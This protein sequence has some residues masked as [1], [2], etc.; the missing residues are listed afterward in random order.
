[1]TAYLVIFNRE[2][3]SGIYIFYI[4]LTLSTAAYSLSA[5]SSVFMGLAAFVIFGLAALFVTD[6]LKTYVNE[7]NYKEIRGGSEFLAEL[8]N[9][10][11]VRKLY[12][13]VTVSALTNGRMLSYTINGTISKQLMFIITLSDF[14]NDFC[15]TSYTG[16]LYTDVGWVAL[17]DK[18]KV[19]LPEENPEEIEKAI[20]SA[21]CAG[22]NLLF[23]S[24]EIEYSIEKSQSVK[25][26]FTPYFAFSE[27]GF[28]E[29]STEYLSMYDLTPERVGAAL[30]GE[31][32]AE[33][34]E[35]LISREEEYRK[36]VYESCYLY[37]PEDIKEKL[38]QDYGDLR[39]AE[40]TS[41]LI[42]DLK[43]RL[44]ENIS[45]TIT[46][47]AVP[48]GADPVEFTLQ[49]RE[50]D[51]NR[52]ASV[53]IMALRYLGYPARYAEGAAISAESKA[54]ATQVGDRYKID[55]Y[56][57]DAIAYGE[58][59]ID[60]LGWLPVNFLPDDAGDLAEAQIDSLNNRETTELGTVVK[61]AAAPYIKTA[62]R[63]CVKILS[64]LCVIS[65]VILIIRRYAIIVLRTVRLASKRKETKK[66]AL[67]KYTEEAK[68][69]FNE[70]IFEE[71]ELNERLNE[72][73]Y[74]RSSENNP[75]D[76]FKEARAAV[77]SR[78][79]TAGIV[80]RFIAFIFKII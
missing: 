20:I 25:T 56:N 16:D 41:Q 35:S 58:V 46:P 22:Q 32:S 23:N 19:N 79:K 17:M 29:L 21:D 50:A 2:Y 24:S 76:L 59:Y 66:E 30:Y 74:S 67:Y 4:I 9:T 8:D 45:F 47:E 14:E 6:N 64:A 43:T 52:L 75:S 15:L 34:A 18:H 53:G 26:S 37:V 77:K 71:S 10:S 39:E 3:D 11:V 27:N 49:Q 7:D 44:N 5:G 13:D 68:A 78:L 12:P 63:V 55:V 51:S 57:L 38:E 73:L 62:A 40:F 28:Y 69:F 36:F 61:A 80:K 72:C 42:N 60:G 31:M 54:D 70:N 33:E 65:A 48:E 1:I